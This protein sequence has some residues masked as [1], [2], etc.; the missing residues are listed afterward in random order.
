MKTR[1]RILLCTLQLFN[2]QGEPNVTTLDIANEL[3][4]SP[5]NL[6]YHFRGKEVL[7]D[8][9]L[10]DFLEQ[11]GELVTLQ[12]DPNE[13][14]PED[15]WL[16]MHLLFEAIIRYRFLFLDLPNLMGRYPQVQR[17]M[18]HWLEALRTSL[19]DMLTDMRREQWL[20]CNEEQLE[21]LA[22][23]LCQLMVFW[24][25]YQRVRHLDEADPNAAV[26]QALGMLLPYM[27]E[28]ARG[29]LKSLIDRY[30]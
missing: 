13:L 20:A 28:S 2:E 3:D 27:A 25:D 22:D 24:I 8:S 29:V 10:A 15:Y 12:A 1:E 21:G 17:A 30:R 26:R 5:G 4:I 9:L 14:N 23:C 11:T 6:Y 19:K 16:F 7:V 18:H